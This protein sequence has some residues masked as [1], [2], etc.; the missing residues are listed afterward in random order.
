M[1]EESS[2]HPELSSGPSHSIRAGMEEGG[3]FLPR[4]WSREWV[5]L[6]R[7]M[8]GNGAFVR[9][10]KSGGWEGTDRLYGAVREKSI[11]FLKILSRLFGKTL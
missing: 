5:I 8:G 4:Q 6:W 11:D 7:G 10:K 9:K 1:R 2:I 3:A